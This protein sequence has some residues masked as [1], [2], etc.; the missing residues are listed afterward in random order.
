MKVKIG[1]QEC[2]VIITNRVIW[3]IEEVFDK[4]ISKVMD[5]V[6]TMK[7]KELALLI[8]E[9][10]KDDITFDEFADS[11]EITQYI[12]AATVVLS[13]IRRAFGLDEKKK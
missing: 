10:I 11:I 1:K 13:E 7:T 9:A 5:S 3:S 4:E 6:G 2:N 8:Y 12:K